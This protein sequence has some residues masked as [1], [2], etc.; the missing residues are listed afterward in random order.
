VKRHSPT[1]GFFQEGRAKA[2]IDALKA[3]LALTALV[4]RDGE[5]VRLPASD[6]V[7]GDAI[8]LP[9]GALAPAGAR[10]ISGSVMVD[11]D[12]NGQSRVVVPRLVNAR[13][14]TRPSPS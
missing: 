2:A 10:I 6:L 13:G 5:W 8:R 11:R 3:R 4:R 9:L 12:F 14:R 7:P 1:L